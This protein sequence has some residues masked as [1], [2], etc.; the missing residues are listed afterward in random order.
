[1]QPHDLDGERAY[2]AFVNGDD[3]LEGLL[4]F[5]IFKQHER[6]WEEKHLSEYGLQP[7]EMDRRTFIDSALTS[8]FQYR[9]EASNALLAFADSAVEDR[10]RAIETEAIEG[11][12][13]KATSLPRAIFASIVGFLAVS[14]L[15]VI[16]S[17]VVSVLG[18][19]LIDALK[20]GAD[21]VNT[22]ENTQNL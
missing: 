19:D 7:S 2:S 17:F 10:K 18:I 9:G 20:F 1:M 15:L 22:P 5:A 16:L 14:A 6:R 3:D 8:L 4:A 11:Q 12:I 13:S 21:D